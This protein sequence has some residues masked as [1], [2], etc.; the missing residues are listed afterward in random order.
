MAYG[1]RDITPVVGENVTYVVSQEESL[2]YNL[3]AFAQAYPATI[4][5]VHTPTCVDLS[6]TLNVPAA[7]AK[8]AAIT[9]FSIT[10]N[11]V[12]FTAANNFSPDDV[13]LI[14]GLSVGAYMNFQSMTV[15]SSNGA[16]FTAAFSQPDVGSTS[17]TGTAKQ[18]QKNLT[19]ANVTFGNSQRNW[20]SGQVFSGVVPTGSPF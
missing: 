3:D 20:F 18:V 6:V 12:T 8:S 10:S 9:G 5:S 11:V 7:S 1:D 19:L 4:K 13:V 2:R 15:L 16:Q 14:S 17:D